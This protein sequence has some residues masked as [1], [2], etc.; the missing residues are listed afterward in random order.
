MIQ[1]SRFKG[2]KMLINIVFYPM[3]W[4][5]LFHLLGETWNSTRL[6]GH[7]MVNDSIHKPPALPVRI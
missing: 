1:R 2:Y 4:I 7:T 6:T 3:V 5:G